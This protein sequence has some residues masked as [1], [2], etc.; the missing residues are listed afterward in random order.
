MKKQTLAELLRAP[1]CCA[2]LWFSFAATQAGA[3]TTSP[4]TASG[5]EAAPNAVQP[6]DQDENEESIVVLDPFTVTAEEDAGSYRA[7]STLAGTRVRTDL[8]DVASSISVVTAEFLRDTGATN[9]QTL[10]QYTTNTEVGGLYGNYAGVGSTFVEGASEGPNFANPNGNTRVRGLNQADNT[11]DYFLTDI[12]WDSYIVGR[13]DLQRGPNSILFGIGSPSGII[14]ANVNI[15]T[16]KTGGSIENRFDQFGSLRWSMDYNQVLIDDELSVRFAAL[17]D[18]TKYSQKPAYNHDQRLFG[19]VSWNPSFLKSDSASTLFRANFE[20]GTIEANR[21]RVLPPWDRITPYFDPGAFNRKTYDPYYAWAAGAIGYPGASTTPKNFW[22]VQYP[23][24]GVQATANPMFYYDDQ[25]QAQPGIVRQAGSTTYW[26]VNTAG[27]RDGGIDGFPYG[28]NVGIGSYNEMAYNDWRTNGDRFYPAADKGFYKSKSLTDPT[29]FDFYNNLLDGPNKWETQDWTAYN[30]TGTQNLLNGRLSLNVAMDHQEYSDAQSR[31]FND[32]FISVDVREYYLAYPSQYADLAVRNPNAGRAFVGGAGAAGSNHTIRDAYRLTLYGDV[33]FKDFMDD[34]FFTTLLGRHLFTGL[35]SADDYTR[36]NRTW[37]R[38]AVD[39]SWSNAIGSGTNGGGSNSGGLVN[40]D[41]RIDTITY[42]SDSLKNTETARGLRLGRIM[43]TQSPFGAYSIPYFDS[44]WKATGVNPA[45][46]WRNP[47]RS[48]DT[49]GEM[50]FESENPY[51]Y[52][53]Y[54][55]DSFDVRNSDRGDRDRLYT[56]VNKQQ[57]KLTSKAITWQGYF[58]DETVVATVGWRTDEQKQRSGASQASPTPDGVASINPALDPLDPTTGITEDDSKSWGVVVHTPKAFRDKLPYRTNISLTYNEGQNSSVENR[59]DFNGQPLPNQKGYTKDMG[60]SLSM[61]DDRLSFRAVYYETDVKDANISSVTTQ[62]STLGSNTYYL[63]LLEAWGV[64]SALLDVSGPQGGAVG[65]EWYW[66]WALVDGDDAPGAA[67]FPDPWS[68][69]YNNLTSPE[70]LN[71]PSTIAQKAAVSSW[72]SQLPSQAWFDAYG[73]AIDVDKAAAGD[74]RNAIAGWTPT[75][76]VGGVQASG[77][78]RINGSWPTGTVD[79]RSEGWEFELAGSPTRNLNI[80]L[81]ASKTFASQTALGASLV[82]YLEAANAKYRS[83]AGDLR[84]WW[85][86]DAQLEAYWDNNIWSAYQFQLQTN[87]KLVPELAPWRANLVMNYSFDEGMLKGANIGLGYRWQDKRVLGY[88][89]NEDGD[90][91]DVDKPY[92]SST[93]DW[94]DLWA[95]YQR[96][97]S[98][99]ITWRIQGNVRNLGKS[100]YLSK[101][102]VQPNGQPAMYKISEGTVWQITNTFSF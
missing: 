18:D 51:N 23:G 79:N 96:K 88:A 78:G 33:R 20:S 11:R 31:N 67:G 49:G 62:A 15:A 102:S 86:G 52:T 69:I 75:S 47:A 21:P 28:S 36:E 94:L 19:T 24:P 66:N 12:P 73:I 87:G 26:G 48:P 43:A 92:W 97:L 9:N 10:L 40:G 30:I 93:E 58:W 1:L 14:N 53:G 70:Y 13:V 60:V 42:L 91:L 50:T 98:D 59:Y 46:P 65:W 45:T 5:T 72:L 95:G 29:I 90:N 41:Q 64:A 74:W 56:S 68:G 76:G 6:T 81:N 32:G 16:M 55:T 84:L 80:S 27:V 71:H 39:S 82:N 54:V 34:G 37:T 57:K 25:R 17:D 4:G 61:L 85:G 83:P 99:K 89:L 35:Y 38:Y 8:K 2:A 7:T 44:H 77:G 63:Y 101:L 22:L 3:Q 100:S